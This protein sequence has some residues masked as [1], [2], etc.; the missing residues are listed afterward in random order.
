LTRIF[1]FRRRKATFLLLALDDGDFENDMGNTIFG[2]GIG[3]L[4]A[5]AFVSIGQ[6]AQG[7]TNEND[8]VAMA[9]YIVGFMIVGAIAGAV[10]TLKQ[11]PRS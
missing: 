9:I 10:Q 2:A 7:H 8:K 4:I 5:G 11:K 1:Q 6:A 3:F